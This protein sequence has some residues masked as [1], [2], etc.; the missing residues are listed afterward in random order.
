VKSTYGKKT[1]RCAGFTLVELMV[2]MAVASILLGGVLSA[3]TL[4]SHALPDAES[5]SRATTQGYHAAERIADELWVAQSFTQRSG[6]MVE[7]TVADR[8]SDTVAE[9][10]RY[11][12]S[13]VPGDPLTR[14]FN[15]GAFGAVLDDVHKFD[16]NYTTKQQTETSMTT[17]NSQGSETD[18]ASFDSWAGIMPTQFFP[19]PANWMAQYLQIVPPAGA[20]SLS[21][22]RVKLMMWSTIFDPTATV[23]VAIH[24]PQTLGSPQP[25]ATPIGTPAVRLTSSLSASAAWADFTFSDV[26][27]D[28]ADTEYVIVVKATNW[29]TVN[30]RYYYWKSAPADSHILIMSTDGGASWEPRASAYDDNDM[31]FYVYG[32]AQSQT[33]QEMTLT[34]YYMQAVDIVL[35][36]GSD[37]QSEVV[38]AAQVLNR[39]EV[40]GP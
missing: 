31:P 28:P 36:T 14:Q 38:T 9:I 1:A 21:I 35:R 30:V 16:L 11:Q 24:K 2:S 12:W 33:T 7:F 4:A 23:S 6:T 40:T 39:P 15:G 32:T 3:I 37:A 25:Q 10:I 22:T 5:P 19:A 29:G 8:D 17:V 26:V 18:L 34:K 27:I 13:A 20:T